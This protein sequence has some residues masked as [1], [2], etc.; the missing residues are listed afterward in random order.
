MFN[1][2][3][4]WRVFSYGFNPFITI[5]YLDLRKMDHLAR[6]REQDKT[7]DGKP[8]ECFG[9]GEETIDTRHAEFISE[10]EEEERHLLYKTRQCTKGRYGSNKQLKSLHP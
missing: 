8:N 7:G 4:K 6:R 1:E 10:E 2:R 3:V 5:L 9:N